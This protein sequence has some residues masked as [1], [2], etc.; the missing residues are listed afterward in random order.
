M[1]EELRKM[2]VDDCGSQEVQWR[3][4]KLVLLELK[5]EG[6]K[7]WWSGNDVGKDGV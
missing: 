3:G 1:A 2:K 4:Y 5:G 6:K 7:L